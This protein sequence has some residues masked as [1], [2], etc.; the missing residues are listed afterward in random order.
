V[1]KEEIRNAN[2]KYGETKVCDAYLVDDSGLIQ[3]TLWGED[4]E[5]V[6]VGD[7]V[8]IENGY[9]TTFR[10]E[11]QLNVPKKKGKLEILDKPILPL[12]ESPSSD[13]PPSKGND[14]ASKPKEDVESP[15]ASNFPNA[16]KM[17]KGNYQDL[18]KDKMHVIM[19]ID[20]TYNKNAKILPDKKAVENAK[21]DLRGMDLRGMD[22]TNAKLSDAKLAGAD[23]R[24]A[25]LRRADLRRADLY[26]AVL[27]GAKL[28]NADLDYADLSYA[29]LS[30][31][32]LLRV[33]LAKAKR[34]GTVGLDM[35][36]TG[37]IWKGHSKIGKSGSRGW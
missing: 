21:S 2:T 8:S 9:T 17:E 3:L 12:D 4:T 31:V 11:V 33:D 28:T 35:K 36:K 30:D 25:D 32:N 13:K 5:K 16:T 24:R 6:K 27:C 26:N 14:E 20:K 7:K 37:S 18:F 23:L 34:M 1:K 29:D 19:A 10:N 22:L 15:F